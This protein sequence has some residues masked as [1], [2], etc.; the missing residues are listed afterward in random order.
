MFFQT[1]KFMF[2][3]NCLPFSKKLINVP[4]T[5]MLPVENIFNVALGVFNL[6]VTP[7]C[8]SGS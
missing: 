2:F 1:V 4:V 5:V 6:Y 8:N 3:F 7:G